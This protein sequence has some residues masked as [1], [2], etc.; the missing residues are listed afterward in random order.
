M[1]EK[2]DDF[3]RHNTQGATVKEITEKLDWVRMKTWANVRSA[4]N[5]VRRVRRQA[6]GWEEILARDKSAVD[7]SAQGAPC[8]WNRQGALKTQP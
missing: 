6:T 1:Q 7:K 8:I 5:H 2:G 4:N 3:F